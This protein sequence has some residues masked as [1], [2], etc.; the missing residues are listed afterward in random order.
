MVTAQQLPVQVAVRP[1]WWRRL[2][3]ASFVLAGLLARGHV[4][5]A[6]YLVLHAL[7]VIPFMTLLIAGQLI[8]PFRARG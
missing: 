4:Q 7:V 5:D 6:C 3:P 2:S 1:A 8:E